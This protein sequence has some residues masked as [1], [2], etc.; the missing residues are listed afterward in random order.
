M[1]LVSRQPKRI[2]PRMPKRLPLIDQYLL[3]ALSFDGVDDYVSIPHSPSL[4]LA[5]FSII[6]IFK[7]SMTGVWQAMFQKGVVNGNYINYGL[8]IS[9]TNKLCG[10]FGAGTTGP[11]YTGNI[12]VT[13]GRWHC[14]AVTYDRVYLKVYVDGRLDIS[15]ALSYTPYTNTEMLSIGMWYGTSYPYTGLI[16]L[17]LLYSRALSQAEIQ[18]DM[19]NPLS[20][21]RDGLVLFLPMIEGS[22]I[23]VKDYSGLG[24]NGTLYGGVS[25]VELAKYEIPAAIGL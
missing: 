21:V 11:A 5:D 24:N 22:G 23:S 4:N 2:Y 15:Q 7:T 8:Q 18:Y 12:I 17:A 14:G 3:Y 6:L 10:R 1:A 16:A 13:D 25:W 19:Y 9:S 20:P